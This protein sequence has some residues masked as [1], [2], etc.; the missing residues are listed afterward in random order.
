MT[1]LISYDLKL[2]FSPHLSPRHLLVFCLV[3]LLRIPKI[4]IFAE[5]DREPQ[6]VCC[7]S[8]FGT[9]REPR[10]AALR[11]RPRSLCLS[12]FSVP[13]FLVLV[14]KLLSV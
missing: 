12:W 13:L 3:A 14:T 10:T 6:K 11:R 1:K 9:L 4:D 7:L 5:G 2:N 8:A